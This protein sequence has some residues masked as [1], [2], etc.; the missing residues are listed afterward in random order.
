M[1]S[2][3]RSP[4][5]PGFDKY[6]HPTH[7]T[8]QMTARVSQGAVLGFEGLVYR[9]CFTGCVVVQPPRLHF[10]SPTRDPKHS[11]HSCLRSS[12]LTHD[13]THNTHACAGVNP[14]PQTLK[15]L[16]SRSSPLTH[17]WLH[18]AAHLICRY[19]LSRLALQ[20]QTGTLGNSCA[21]K[22]SPQKPNPTLTPGRFHL[23]HP[24][25]TPYPT[26]QPPTP[27]PPLMFWTM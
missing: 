7:H 10:Q 8:S 27:F 4:A 15:H 22:P 9:T 11:Q 19:L 25:Y 3:V 6:T 24:Y 17:D 18:S 13:C 23:H 20:R 5:T 1:S 16:C 26:F 21:P 12:P 14:R 2:A